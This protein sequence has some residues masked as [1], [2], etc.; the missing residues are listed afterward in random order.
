[1]TIIEIVLYERLKATPPK[2]LNRDWCSIK[3]VSMPEM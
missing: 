3:L 1:M 2:P